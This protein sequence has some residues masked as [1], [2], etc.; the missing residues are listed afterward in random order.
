MSKVKV[1]TVEELSKPL[2]KKQKR[3]FKS[4]EEA[5][6]RGYHHGY[7][8]A[9]DDYSHMGAHIKEIPVFFDKFLTPWRYFKDKLSKTETMVMPPEFDVEKWHKGEYDEVSEES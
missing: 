4:M 1:W 6:R 8:T 9:I 2:T 7:S 5:Y 3:V